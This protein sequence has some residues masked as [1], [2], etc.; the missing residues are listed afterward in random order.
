M[1]EEGTEFRT[2]DTEDSRKPERNKDT[3]PL[4]KAIER[5]EVKG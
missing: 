5:K 1:D 4:N 2:Q 3:S